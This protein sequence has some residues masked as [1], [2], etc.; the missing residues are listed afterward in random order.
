MLYLLTFSPSVSGLTERLQKFFAGAGVGMTV[1]KQRYHFE[2]LPSRMNDGRMIVVLDEAVQRWEVMLPSRV[3]NL[4]YELKSGE[5]IG[6]KYG[7]CT[8]VATQQG[9]LSSETMLTAPLPP[10]IDR[11]L[12]EQAFRFL[13]AWQLSPP[14]SLKRFLH[15]PPRDP[16]P[17]EYWSRLREWEPFKSEFARRPEVSAESYRTLH[18]AL[19]RLVELL[20]TWDVLQPF[21]DEAAL[22]TASYTILRYQSN[23]DPHWFLQERFQRTESNDEPE[24]PSPLDHLKITMSLLGSRIHPALAAYQARLL[25]ADSQHRP[26]REEQVRAA[27]ELKDRLPYLEQL[28][29]T[30]ESELEEA[31]ETMPEPQDELGEAEADEPAAFQGR[32]PG[33]ADFRALEAYN[34]AHRNMIDAPDEANLHRQIYAWLAEHGCG[35][36]LADYKLPKFDTWQRQKNRAEKW[37]NKRT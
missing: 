30:I 29:S 6:A 37:Q 26:S 28:L 11:A 14:D 8:E 5:Y 7:P 33:P 36:E 12:P 27:E 23:S 18:A 3:M 24:E 16:R 22:Q 31:D 13:I 25:P 1:L 35:P 17:L 10:E 34:Y 21:P 15:D 2:S 4:L 20:P 19:S 9:W 32:A